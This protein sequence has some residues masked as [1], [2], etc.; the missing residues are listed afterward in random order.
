MNLKSLGMFLA[1]AAI[2]ASCTNDDLMDDSG[3]RIPEGRAEIQ[4]NFSGSGESQEYSTTRAIASDSENRIDKLEVYL[5]ASDAQ[6]GTYRFLEKWDEGTAYD[7]A[8]PTD[9]NFKKI[10]AGTGWKASLYP[11][12][13]KGLPW[14]KLLCVVNN[15][16]DGH[17]GIADGKF[18]D[19]GNPTDAD[20][21][22]ATPK[23]DPT[24]V[25]V[26]ADGNVTNPDAATTEAEFKKA[27]TRYLDPADHATGV[28][29]VPLMMT[30]E[31]V[32]KIS[33][34]V[35]KVNIDLRRT[36]ARFDIEN[37]KSKSNLTIESVTLNRGRRNGALWG[38]ERTVVASA[39]FATSAFLADYTTIDFKSKT[40]ANKGVV[41]SVFYAYPNL[42]S[43][44]AYLVVKGTYKS[45]VTS[46][47][48][49]VVYNIDLAATPEGSDMAKFIS[50]KANSR[51]RLKIM[52]VTKSHIFATF[53][54]VDWTSGGGIDVK[55]DNDAPVFDPA[56]AFL[57]TQPA[58][59]IPVD[60]NAANPEAVTSDYEVVG[61]AGSFKLMIAATGKVRAEKAPLTVTRADESAAYW[62]DFSS[63]ECTEKDGVWYSEFTVN[64]SGAVGARPVAVNFINDAASFDPELWTTVNFYGPKQVPL[65]YDATAPNATGNSV[66]VTD[67]KAPKATLYRTAGS[68]VMLDVK[69]GEGIQV[70]KQIQGINAEEVKAEGDVHT[71]KVSVTDAKASTVSGNIVFANSGDITKTTD[72]AITVK[73]AAMTFSVSAPDAA[74][75]VTADAADANGY[76]PGQEVKIDL[77]ALVGKTFKFR[78]TSPIDFTV[79]DLTCP[80]LTIADAG[81]AWSEVEPW[82]EFTITPSGV[83]S[84]ET[85]TKLTFKNPLSM[86]EPVINAPA[87]E[88]RLKKDFTKPI[89]S[90]GTTAASWSAFNQAF[91]AAATATEIEM[92]R[93][94]NSTV[95]V[96]V[97]CSNEAVEFASVAGVEVT[98]V[99]ENKGEYMVTVSDTALLTNKKEVELTVYNKAA[100]EA[101]TD[102]TTR[103]A[104]IKLKMKDA[105]MSYELTSNAGGSAVI[106]G[107]DKDK[108]VLDYGTFQYAPVVITVK[109]YKG[110][111]IAVSSLADHR[112]SG[113]Q[114]AQI[115]EDGTAVLNFA[116][117]AG[118]TGTGDVTVTITSAIGGPQKVITISAKP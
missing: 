75:Q 104:S 45:P 11:G 113:T 95:T 109:G 50:L 20:P 5:F 67:E 40:G 105:A 15:G 98:P 74:V 59:N 42:D 80:E 61:E 117:N 108:I 19:E 86:T 43:D 100:R 49:P 76:I 115:S 106:D 93:V 107:T 97:D 37:D 2:G 116:N 56:I 7:A 83:S 38:T 85:W 63:V 51:Y 96:S 65:F 90:A 53:E 66:D 103:K 60:L 17:T 24:A 87:L 78:V 13:L 91:M 29:E 44:Q 3:T 28:I 21:A 46:V 18:Y 9:L 33:G 77:A 54:V 79:P 58:T 4:V 12:E 62:I 68:F 16:V 102:A 81:H 57:N 34:S 39:D 48:E 64:Y 99:N 110:S 92:Y 35:S 111:T 73:D 27:F 47:E 118:G 114:P 82:M 101:E 32:T 10:A 94:N 55:P 89:Y 1:L 30:G 71:Y 14:I 31:G 112:L 25:T 69:G 22:K 26:D 88:I 84:T 52:D 70:L 6:D 23:A 36:V 72:L 41:E 8:N